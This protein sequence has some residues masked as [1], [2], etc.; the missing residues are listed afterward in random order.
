M[1]K[2]EVLSLPVE[3]LKLSQSAL[4][5][6]KLSGIGRLE[7]FNTFNLKELQM[8]LGESF[9]EVLPTLIYYKLPRDV[10]DL[11]L[12]DEAVSVLETAGIKDLESL[13][14]YDKTTLYHI[15]KEDEFLLRSEEHTSELQSRPH[16]V[17]RLLLEKKNI[18]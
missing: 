4:D 9:T 17:C 5:R 3:S 16:L 7:D 6:L 15:F 14:K 11:S 1:A 8:L 12:S 18:R 2:N 13:T 10:K